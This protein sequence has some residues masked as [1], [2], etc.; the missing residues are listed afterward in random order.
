[1]IH[2]LARNGRL[3][4]C[5]E[6]AAFCRTVDHDNIFAITSAMEDGDLCRPCRAAARI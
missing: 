2:I 3:T 5:G 6:L 4:L 1:M